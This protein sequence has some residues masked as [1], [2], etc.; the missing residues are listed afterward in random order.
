[1]PL[2]FDKFDFVGL[3]ILIYCLFV[4]KLQEEK[5]QEIFFKK[6]LCR[7][8]SFDS[9]SAKQRKLMLFHCTKCLKY[10]SRPRV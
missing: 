2:G 3:W 4:E 6:K 5:Y 7:I 9:F 8:S 10:F 1:M